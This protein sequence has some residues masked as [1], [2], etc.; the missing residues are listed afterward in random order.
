[1]FVETLLEL[2]L[3]SVKLFHSGLQFGEIDRCA[4]GHSKI[5]DMNVMV[6]LLSYCDVRFT[7]LTLRGVSFFGQ[8]FKAGDEVEQLFV[9]ATLGNS[10][11][12]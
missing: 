5:F 8:R 6:I 3:R 10:W 11:K 12:R 1:M 7:L 9:N 4:F 2:R